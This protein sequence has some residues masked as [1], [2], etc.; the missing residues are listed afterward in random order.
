M[1]VTAAAAVLSLCLT[2]A[3]HAQAPPLYIPF[4][5]V[6]LDELGNPRTGLTSLVFSLYEEDVDGVPVWVEVQPVVLGIDGSYQV[7]LGG[8]SGGVSTDPFTSGTARWLGV[9]AEGLPEGP[10][11]RLVSVPYAAK[12]A[13]AD[14]VGGLPA[15]SFVLSPDAGGDG[16]APAGVSFLGGDKDGG[17]LNGLDTNTDNLY[18]TN[19]I[20]VGTTN[21]IRQLHLKDSPQSNPLVIDVAANQHSGIWLRENGANKWQFYNETGTD[22]MQLFAYAAARRVV[23]VTST[24]YVGLGTPTPQ[25]QLHLKGSVQNN[26]F[27][28]DTA[29]GRHA[30]IWLR[31]N[32][33]NKWQMYN[34]ALSDDFRMFSYGKSDVALSLED[35]TGRLGIGTSSPSA[36]IHLA[37][38]GGALLQ[39]ESSGS[40]AQIRFANSDNNN[41]FIQYSGGNLRF[42]ASSASQPTLT[43]SGGSPG[44]VGI[45]TASPSSKLHVNGNVQVDGNIAAKYQDVAE[46]VVVD[47]YIPAGNVVVID[48]NASNQVLPSGAAYDTG[49][50]G[51]VSAQPGLVLGIAGDNKVLVAQ[52][53]RVKVKADASYGAISAGDILATSPNPGHAMRSEPVD[54]GP[55]TVHRPGTVLGKA[56]EALE[57]GTGEILVLLT[58]Q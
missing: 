18:V 36:K 7:L 15:S 4:D 11:S 27:I 13:D 20:G 5:G 58:L 9:Q 46:W 29:E 16:A 10:R 33:V 14:T 12:A 55:V 30:G 26:P 57:S 2:G 53:G 3:A 21:P 37:D 44:N 56:L 40:A 1:R 54:L 25:R 8:V 17:T 22:S 52:S 48:P 32:S 23:T 38:A 24:G 39:L 34:D 41:G 19:R 28:I 6:I 51:A 50:A 47:E 49:V 42:F 31:E 45:G 43:L 35:V